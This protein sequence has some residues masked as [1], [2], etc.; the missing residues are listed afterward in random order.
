MKSFLKKNTPV[1]NGKN[2]CGIKGIKHSEV[3]AVSNSA[4]SHYNTV[5]YFPELVYF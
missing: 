3:V 1:I 2:H 4:S 5:D